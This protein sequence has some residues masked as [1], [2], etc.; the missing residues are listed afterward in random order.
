[1]ITPPVVHLHRNA[2]I[3]KIIPVIHFFGEFDPYIAFLRISPRKQYSCSV[4]GVVD[5]H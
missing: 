5:M 1:L 3:R 4:F 2:R